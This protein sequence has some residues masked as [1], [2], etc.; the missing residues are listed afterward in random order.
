MNKINTA[1]ATTTTTITTTATTT[2]T[3]TT[4]TT[5]TTTATTTT[6]TTTTNNNNINKI[7]TFA[8]RLKCYYMKLMPVLFL[9]NMYFLFC[10]L[11]SETCMT[12]Y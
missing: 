8:N 11:T 12:M 4:T 1:A 5:I 2:N 9:I 10:S 7:I 3:T 6:T